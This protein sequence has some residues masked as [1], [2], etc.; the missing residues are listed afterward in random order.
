MTQS[1]KILSIQVGSAKPMKIGERK[2]LS[3]IH[4]TPI[5]GQ[6]KVNRLGLEG[7]EQADLTVHGGL[8][9]AIYAYPSEHYSYWSEQKAALDLVADLPFGSMGENLTLSGLLEKELFVGDA[10][11]FPDCVLHVTQPR[12]PCFKFNAVMGDK[13]AAKKMAQTGFCGFYL[14]VVA[15]GSLRPGDSFKLVAGK[16]QTLIH[17]LFKASMMKTRY[18]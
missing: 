18:D 16:R 11:H 8:S 9:K 3:A 17:S 1:L 15:G 2:V 14:S 6:V 13:L 7:D 4:K 12:Q 5:E 10:L